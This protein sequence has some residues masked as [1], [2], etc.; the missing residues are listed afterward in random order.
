MN[1]E[2]I[3]TYLKKF[4]KNG[5]KPGLERIQ[6]LLEIL[7]NP[8]NS[9]KIIHVSGTNGK[10]STCRMI[11]S[12]LQKADYKTGLFTSPYL[13][14]I[15]EMF[16]IDK[17]IDNESLAILIKEISLLVDTNEYLKNNLTE[18][19]FITAA[20]IYYFKQSSCEFVLLEAGMGGSLDATNAVS[21]LV[22][23]ITKISFDHMDYLGTSINEIAEAESGI[24][25]DNKI[26]VIGSQ[27]FLEAENII[28]NKA[29]IA[30]N[31]VYSVNKEALKILTNNTFSYKEFL[32]IKLS[33]LGSH[34]IENALTVLETI[35]ALKDLNYLIDI[36]HIQ[37]ALNNVFWPGRLEQIKP[38]V[39]L[40]V[41]HNVDGVYSLVNFLKAYYPERKINFIFGVL[42]DKQ[43]RHMIEIFVPITN[44]LYLVKPESERALDPFWLSMILSEYGI[45]AKVSKDI[46]EALNLI[47]SETKKDDIICI[48]GSFYLV[49]PAREIL[50]GV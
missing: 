24:I 7:G 46:K 47:F 15:N 4:R 40:D 9:L 43:Y 50:K 36:R 26:T 3:L 14:K 11:T 22:S 18:F 39:F 20:A 35:C 17:D 12:I 8:Q 2:K 30:S 13:V 25:K 32:N 33:L 21:P 45:K 23:I 19:E 48:F 38:N 29:F 37:E 49:G 16:H 34:Q 27:S 44:N 6:R 10:G 41:S 28:Q 42:E 31:K 1:Y 5:I